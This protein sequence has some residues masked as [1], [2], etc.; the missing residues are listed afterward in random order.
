MFAYLLSKDSIIQGFISV[1]TL[2]LWIAI[3]LHVIIPSFFSLLNYFTNG[4]YL[5]LV[6]NYNYLV[7][8]NEFIKYQP[9]LIEL[10]IINSISP[11][12]LLS[13]LSPLKIY[14]PFNDDNYIN[15]ISYS[16]LLIVLSGFFHIGVSIG[17][18]LLTSGKRSTIRKIALVTLKS[19]LV[20]IGLQLLLSNVFYID[21]SSLIGMS[22]II[23][24]FLS[25]F[26]AVEASEI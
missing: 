13:F 21:Y 11:E 2:L 16:F 19:S 18:F 7:W 24:F 23:L 26:F 4:A 5:H 3:F 10:K 6:D 12:S 14:V 15:I 22:T 20:T 25:L 17:L 9:E 1:F 8:W